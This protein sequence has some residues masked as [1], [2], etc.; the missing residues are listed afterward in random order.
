MLE[1]FHVGFYYV[2]KLQISIP[3]WIAAT[4]AAVCCV[5]YVVQC[6]STTQCLYFIGLFSTIAS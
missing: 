3:I 2:T 5:V 1:Y 4:A 6:P